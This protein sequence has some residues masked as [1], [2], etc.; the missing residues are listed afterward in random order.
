MSLDDFNDEAFIRELD[1]IFDFFNSPL[2]EMNHTA[3]KCKKLADEIKSTIPNLDKE[4][5]YRQFLEIQDSIKEEFSKKG[6]YQSK[7]A[8]KLIGDFEKSKKEHRV[9]SEN[10]FSTSGSY[11]RTQ[12]SI[13][14]YENVNRLEGAILR[15]PKE[16]QPYEK[17][18]EIR[19]V[20]ISYVYASLVGG[21]FRFTLQEVYR[22]TRI[23]NGEKI[24]PDAITDMDVEQI[25]NYYKAKDDLLYFEGYEP[26]I[27]HAVAHSN[28][29]YDK[30][31][32]KITYV[33]EKR[34]KQEDGSNPLKEF[35]LECDFIDV[36][37]RYEKIKSLYHLTIILKTIWR[38]ETILAHITKRH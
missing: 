24:N 27:R 33:N 30:T 4:N 16:P 28:F 23:S 21:I 14:N 5:I 15:E 10:A 9:D 1:N 26:I 32:E 13:S 22:W 8:D 34:V 20:G 38:I 7:I 6:D 31:T 12:Q 25:R 18:K 35:K 17:E 19:F 11:E 2:I 37:E 3:Q 36:H 29:K